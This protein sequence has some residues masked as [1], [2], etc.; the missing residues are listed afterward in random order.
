MA[1]TF[2]LTEIV[3]RKQ[4]VKPLACGFNEKF[5]VTNLD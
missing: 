1:Q 3:V 2:P 5:T 4:L